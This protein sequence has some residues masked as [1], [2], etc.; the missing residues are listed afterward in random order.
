M[1]EMAFFFAATDDN[2]DQEAGGWGSAGAAPVRPRPVAV[3]A[4]RRRSDGPAGCLAVDGRHLLAGLP[5]SFWPPTS[6][7]LGTQRQCKWKTSKDDSLERYS[8]VSIVA[9]CKC[10][11]KCKCK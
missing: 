5:Q 10:K 3:P 6:R 2:D 1:K 8:N 7:L 4:H 9:E 11:W